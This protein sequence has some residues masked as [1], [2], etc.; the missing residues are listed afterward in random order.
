M[1]FKFCCRSAE[2]LT[3]EA[4]S[5]RKETADAKSAKNDTTDA[6]LVGKETTD[7][8]LMKEKPV[9]E[10]PA[11]E[12]SAPEKMPNPK[13]GEFKTPV[14]SSCHIATKP[15]I[16]KPIPAKTPPALPKD[17]I[18]LG[19][20]LA[21]QAFAADEIPVGAVIFNSNTFEIIA[22][23]HNETVD[24]HNPLAHA[25]IVAINLALKKTGAKLL[26][27][28]SIFVTLE[29]CVMCAGAISWARLDNLYYGAFDPKT[30]AI[31]QGAEVFTQPQT[32]HKPTI[33]GGIKADECGTLMS[34]FFKNKRTKKG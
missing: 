2:K 22:A 31:N 33:Q 1:P 19:I 12:K 8:K 25:E 9:G 4:N 17:I 34:Q 23:A 16:K 32:H 13:M 18:D 29:P 6:K 21:R 10:K 14:G 11:S 30:G 15:A 20:Q 27:R 24:K 26:D 28:Y 3:L 5:A 7:A